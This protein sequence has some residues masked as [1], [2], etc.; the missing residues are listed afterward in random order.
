MEKIIF[1]KFTNTLSFGSHKKK[2]GSKDAL[3]LECLLM[4]GIEGASKNDIISYAWKGLIVT[5]ASLSKSISTLRAALTEFNSNEEIILTIPRTGYKI[6]T[7]KISLCEQDKSEAQS[8]AQ[9]ESKNDIAVF[10]K[11]YVAPRYINLIISI[12]TMGILTIYTHRLIDSISYSTQVYS[13]PTLTKESLP[14]NNEV[15]FHQGV[16]QAF[17][18]EIALKVSCQCIFFVSSNEQF[19]F[20]SIY[21]KD[22]SKALNFMFHKEDKIVAME[23]YIQ[24]K[25]DTGDNDE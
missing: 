22:R 13:S 15:I 24:E 4:A 12:I 5:D 17:F 11:V 2:V 25:I 14:N 19:S 23:S 1:D 9:L 8:K 7:S 6:D 16:D 21:L 3:V 10:R 20:I 18:R